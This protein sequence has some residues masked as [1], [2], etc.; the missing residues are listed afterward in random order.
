[1]SFVH[2]SIFFACAKAAVDS[3][4]KIDADDKPKKKKGKKKG[5]HAPRQVTPEQMAIKQ[6]LDELVSKHERHETEHMATL[7][8][9]AEESKE[10]IESIGRHAIERSQGFYDAQVVKQQTQAEY[11]ELLKESIT[12]G[13]E[14]AQRATDLTR[15]E[16]AFHAFLLGEYTFLFGFDYDSYC[17]FVK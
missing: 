9:W 1:M 10:I 6:K 7:R 5:G 16:A 4:D 3:K 17:K 14:C 11:T 15:A 12:V 2:C 8:R 13:D